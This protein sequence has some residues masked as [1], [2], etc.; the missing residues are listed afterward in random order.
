MLLYACLPILLTLGV[1]VE[2][3]SVDGNVSVGQLVS[4]DT[5]VTLAAAD[6][7]MKQVSTE[8]TLTI[9]R[10]GE[11][12]AKTAA[13]ESW[14]TLICGT[15][16]VATEVRSDETS[17]MVTACDCRHRIG[18]NRVRALRFNPPSNLDAQWGEILQSEFVGDVLVIRRDN[19]SLD[20]L[21][22]VVREFTDQSVS[23]EYDGEVLEVPRSKLEGAIF[24][25]PDASEPPRVKL[26]TVDDGLFH[27][28]R[29]SIHDGKILARTT[30]DVELNLPLEQLRR[31]DFRG[32]KILY[33]GD[34]TPHRVQIG[35]SGPS[36][37]QSRALERL[38]YQPRANAGLFGNRLALRLTGNEGIR[39]FSKGLA[40]HSRTEITYRLQ[41]DYTQLKAIVGM[42]PRSAARGLVKLVIYNGTQELF[43]QEIAAEDDAFELDLDISGTKR[44]RILVDYADNWDL[45]DHLNLCDLRLT[46]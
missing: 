15:Q 46:K 28:D 14:I 30:S 2:L 31:L 9:Q 38:L 35:T 44:L 34:V 42:D 41:E 32:G 20:Y 24:F 12:P 13:K 27:L 22:G 3:R 23:F 19:D 17:L 8:S 5:E 4:L 39:Y 33:L 40:L 45:S 7:T 37:V 29:L 36:S 18:R 11:V 10:T 16:L 26:A 6:G 43:S 25:R 1:D 21:E